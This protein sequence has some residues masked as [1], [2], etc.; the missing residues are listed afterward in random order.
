MEGCTKE[1]FEDL[2]P[3][4]CEKDGRA[5]LLR[6]A[7]LLMDPPKNEQFQNIVALA[8]RSIVRKEE[9][10]PHFL[11]YSTLAELVFGTVL[12]PDGEA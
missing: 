10:L 5:A 12:D 3:E 11:I 4:D 8:Q 9:L 2:K 7:M 6:L 1:T